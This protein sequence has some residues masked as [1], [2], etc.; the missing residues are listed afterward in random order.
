VTIKVLDGC[1]FNNHYWAF[2]SGM[3]N[4]EVTVTVTDTLTGA[5][6]TYSNPQGRPFR[7]SLDTSAFAT[8]G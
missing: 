2:V 8:C 6:K 1:G 3:T 7:T 5:T 4:V